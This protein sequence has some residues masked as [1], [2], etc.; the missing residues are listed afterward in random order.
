MNEAIYNGLP[1]VFTGSVS[2]TEEINL[3]GLEVEP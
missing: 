3:D 1:V 2:E